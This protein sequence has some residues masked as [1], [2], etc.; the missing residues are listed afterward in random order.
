MGW[1]Q[2]VLYFAVLLLCA[3]PLGLYM[4]RKVIVAHGGAILFKSEPGKGSTFGFKFPL[5]VV[6]VGESK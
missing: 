4:A 1:L 3:K 5:T 2:I 6:R